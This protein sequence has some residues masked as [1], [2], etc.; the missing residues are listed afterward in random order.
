MKFYW[1]IFAD[2]YRTCCRGLDRVEL[3]HEVLKH[4]K[5]M[6]KVPA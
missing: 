6:S 1:F 4:G 2:G 3:K 5:L